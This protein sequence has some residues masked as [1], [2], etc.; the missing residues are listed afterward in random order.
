MRM[1][2]TIW[3]G[4]LASLVALTVVSMPAAAQQ[5]QRP[6]IIFIMGDDIGW[7]NIS[8]YHR[9]IMAGRTPNLDQLASEGMSLPT[10]MLK[11][12]AQRAAPTSSPASCRSVPG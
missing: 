2:R 4:V 7:F 8:A 11:R 10:T 5:Q 1:T 9:G 12:A 6:N 3:L